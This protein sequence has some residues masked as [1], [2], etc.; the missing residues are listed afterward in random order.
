MYKNPGI[1]GFDLASDVLI[2]HALPFDHDS[3][4]QYV[5]F[6]VLYILEH[7]SISTTTVLVRP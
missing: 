1:H 3:A 5:L 7:K 6:E 4:A 2:L